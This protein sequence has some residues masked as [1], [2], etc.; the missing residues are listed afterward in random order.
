MQELLLAL[1]AWDALVGCYLPRPLSISTSLGSSN[2]MAKE[3][4]AVIAN[5]SILGRAKATA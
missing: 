1:A 2:D 3:C 4:V 5:N